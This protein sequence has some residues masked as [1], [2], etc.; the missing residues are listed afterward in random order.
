MSRDSCENLNP[1]QRLYTSWLSNF[2][3]WKSVCLEYNL[4]Y[5]FI[6]ESGCAPDALPAHFGKHAPW[7]QPSMQYAAY[8]LEC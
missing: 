2:R 7:D 6:C 4:F 5:I 1:K 8:Y 3:L